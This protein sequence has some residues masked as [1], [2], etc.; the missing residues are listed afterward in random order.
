MDSKDVTLQVLVD[1]RDEIRGTNKRVDE[2]KERVD[3]LEENVTRE[4]KETNVRI[5]RLTDR[6]VASEIRVASALTEVV[7][8]MNDVKSMLSER[9]DLRDRVAN[10]ERDIA[11]LKADKKK[12]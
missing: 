9:L 2:L 10:C 5:D 4:I 3:H 6:V 11:E 8:S 7:G 1:I 12:N